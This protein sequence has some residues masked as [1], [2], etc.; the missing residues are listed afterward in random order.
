MH[1]AFLRILR[2]LFCVLMAGSSV[3][4]EKIVVAAFEYPPIYQDGKNKGLSGDIV[5]AAFKAANID[6]DMHFFPVS[7]MVLAVSQGQAVCGIG[8]TVLFA[9]PDVAPNVTV[10]SVVQYVYQTFLYDTRRF[11]HGLAFESLA[12][13]AQYRIGVLRG[14]G[15][16]KF[17][18]K[19][20][21]LTFYPGSA[22]EGAAKQLQQR[23]I[24]A[25]A[26]VDL[27]GLMVMNSLF[28]DEA[29]HYRYSRAFN[30]GDV[31]LVCSKKR[32]P[33]DKYGTKFRAGLASIK[34]NGTYM[35]I[36]AKYYGGAAKINKESLT[37][38]MR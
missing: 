25:W 16:M 11:P 10:T 1:S 24:D 6:V 36:M 28:P 18:E 31:S 32:D 5:V 26:I 30:L 2:I 8:G 29:A 4:N 9:A 22:H 15:I 38:D 33:E 17:L 37:A 35:Q 13:M 19:T 7:R 21:E 34:K 20:R 3:A 14:S 12:D 27:T 23:R